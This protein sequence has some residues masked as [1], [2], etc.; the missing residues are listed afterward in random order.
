[1]KEGTRTEQRNGLRCSP[2]PFAG[3]PRCVALVPKSVY[4]SLPPARAE[5][6]GGQGEVSGVRCPP[7]SPCHYRRCG[8]AM[9]GR[10][11]LILMPRFEPSGPL[12]ISGKN[13]QKSDTVPAAFEAA[14]AAFGHVSRASP[15]SESAERA[16]I[17]DDLLRLSLRKLPRWRRA[18]FSCAAAGSGNY[19]SEPNGLPCLVRLFPAAVE[20]DKLDDYGSFGSF[21][22]RPLLTESVTFHYT[23]KTRRGVIQNCSPFGDI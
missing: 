17:A 9:R 13:K 4:F 16:E 1:M 2:P 20:A 5:G 19:R 10:P 14:S 8:G 15:L 22:R 7:L 3:A 21:R 23:I 18:P 12:S 6:E 11:R